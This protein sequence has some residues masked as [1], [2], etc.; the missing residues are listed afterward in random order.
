M[1]L[2]H[3]LTVFG[4]EIRIR[5]HF[6]MNWCQDWSRIWGSSKFC[7]FRTL[8]VVA[9][10]HIATA[11]WM[12]PHQVLQSERWVKFVNVTQIM[13]HGSER[14]CENIMKTCCTSL[15]PSK[16]DNGE[17]KTVLEIVWRHWWTAPWS[18][19]ECSQE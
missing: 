1:K 19:L 2:Y 10:G 16:Q 12:H 15:V 3:W 9:L 8:L 7:F 5:F 13:R 6:L 4:N 11:T 14:L 18:K 17:E